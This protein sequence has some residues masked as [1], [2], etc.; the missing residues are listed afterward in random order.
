MCGDE[1]RH[2]LFDRARK[3][4]GLTITQLWVDYLALG[5]RMDLFNVEA[6]LHGLVLLP[7]SQQDVLA[8]V[9]NE[10]LDDLCRAAKVPYLFTSPD[11]GLPATDP[12]DVL[13]E[14]L[15]GP[16]PSL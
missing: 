15:R 10:R 6:Y 5:G 12:V 13:D 16:P 14:L 8:N 11:L 1:C 3:Q 9:L 7:P 4:A 2:E